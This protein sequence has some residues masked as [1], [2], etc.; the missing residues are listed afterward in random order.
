MIRDTIHNYLVITRANTKNARSETFKISH[1]KSSNVITM[2]VFKA[3]FLGE[4][5]VGKTSIGLKWSEGTFD[6]QR[7][8]T[9]QAG[10]YTKRVDTSKGM[11]EVNLWDTAGQEEYHAVAPI[12]YKNSHAAILVYSVTDERSFERM[13]QWHRELSQIAGDVKIVVAANKID[14]AK[15]RVI[16]TSRGVEYAQSI[17][18]MHF[19]VSAKTGEGIEML[20][21]YLTEELAK[22]NTGVRAAARRGKRGALVVS[23]EAQATSSRSTVD[24]QGGNQA[25]G[26]DC[27]C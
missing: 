12:Y 23:E 6:P 21:K 7:R 1:R 17:G 5:R 20:F 27:K 25:E 2:N 22:S 14:L 11:I 3:V 15:D 10:L 26:G 13:V 16:P 9:V 8:S 18:C 19:E 4:G 24:L